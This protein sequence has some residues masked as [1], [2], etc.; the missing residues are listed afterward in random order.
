[1]PRHARQDVGLQLS[2]Q[3]RSGLAPEAL[4]HMAKIDP[5]QGALLPLAAM[6]PQ[7]GLNELAAQEQI[8]P[9]MSQ[10]HRQ[11]VADQP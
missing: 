6:Q 11:L 2:A 8:Q 1:M 7:Q 4:D 9:V 10:V 5:A 3:Q